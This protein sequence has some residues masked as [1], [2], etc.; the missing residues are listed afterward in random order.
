MDGQHH[1]S[2]RR[3]RA[4]G[5]VIVLVVGTGLLAAVPAQAGGPERDVTMLDNRYRPSAAVVTQGQAVEFT[6]FGRV[7]HDAQ[8]GTGLDLFSTDLL[9]PPETAIVGPLPGAGRFGYYCTFHPEMTGRFEVPVRIS[10]TSVVR[11]G[12]VTVRWATDR[13]PTGLVFDVQR[14]RPGSSQYVD[15]RSGVTTPAAKWWPSARGEWA[16]R[17]R[18]RATSGGASSGWSPPRVLRVD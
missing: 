15:W 18:V 3:G 1:A 9:G 6:N 17:A 2:G 8:D 11:G 10:R 5:A 12:Q 7:A 14:R 4:L 16:V 13:A